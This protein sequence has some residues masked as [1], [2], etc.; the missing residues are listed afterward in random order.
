MTSPAVSSAGMSLAAG[1]VTN[2]GRPSPGALTAVNA[3][4][5][6]TS[7]CSTGPADR[8][9]SPRGNGLYTTM[10]TITLGQRHAPLRL[11]W[12]E[13]QL[14]PLVE[15]LRERIGPRQFSPVDGGGL[16]SSLHHGRAP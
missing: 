13:D 1:T 4:S 11:E 7:T 2:C 14:R 5:T 3:G 15:V 16:G 10:Q 6:T 12:S 8:H 9:G